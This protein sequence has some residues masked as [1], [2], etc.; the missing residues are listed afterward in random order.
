VRAYWCSRLQ[1]PVGRRT[2][3]TSLQH[4]QKL[5]ACHGISELAVICRVAVCWLLY[6]V[7]YTFTSSSSSSA[8][9]AAAA[10]RCPSGIGRSLHKS[11]LRLFAFFTQCEMLLY[12][13]SFGYISCLSST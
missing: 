4:A 12:N 11:C 1:I 9:A 2:Q 6:C 8:A 7:S 3:R 5:V 10:T 13:V